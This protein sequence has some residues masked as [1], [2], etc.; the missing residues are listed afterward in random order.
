MYYRLFIVLLVLS[1]LGYGMVLSA[2]THNEIIQMDQSTQ[3]MPDDHVPANPTDHLV[4]GG[5]G[6]HGISHILGLFCHELKLP[7]V[8]NLLFF[9]S[10]T[11]R[12]EFPTYQPA[13]RPPIAI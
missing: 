10:Y 13:F 7:V 6:C 1:I 8:N 11:E 3:I 9:D 5:H 4:D 2:G 12:F